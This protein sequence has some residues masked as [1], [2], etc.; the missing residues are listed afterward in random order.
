PPQ[1]NVG[2]CFKEESPR[3]DLNSPTQGF[4]LAFLIKLFSKRF[5]GTFRSRLSEFHPFSNEIVVQNLQP[6]ALAAE[7]R[8]VLMT[9]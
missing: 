3:P 8:G 1:L 4:G 9:R 5:P 7:L 2:I 6:N